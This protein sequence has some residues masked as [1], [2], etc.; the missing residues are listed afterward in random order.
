MSLGMFGGVS[1][2]SIAWVRCATSACSVSPSSSFWSLFGGQ[3]FPLCFVNIS[4][5]SCPLCLKINW[6]R[7]YFCSQWRTNPWIM[8]KDTTQ[9]M[10][11][12]LICLRKVTLFRS[13]T[14]QNIPLNQQWC[15]RLL[16]KVSW[17]SVNSPGL[18]TIV[19]ESGSQRQNHLFHLCLSGSPAYIHTRCPRVLEMFTFSRKTWS[20]EFWRSLPI[21]KW[22]KKNSNENF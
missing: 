13:T 4:S 8:Q 19:G 11:Y 5:K 15:K 17:F 6:F 2:C 1:D 22:S 7:A 14:T 3:V 20:Q 21:R 9:V 18:V 16:P 12:F 10:I